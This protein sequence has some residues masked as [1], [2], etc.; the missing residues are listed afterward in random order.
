MQCP[1]ARFLLVGDGP[2][3]KRLQAQHPDCYFV[4]M[5][6]GIALAEHYA[7]SDLFLYPSTSETFGNVILEAMA[8]GLPV[9]SFNYAASREYIH[10]GEN[11][12]AVPLY[13][14]QAFIQASITLAINPTLRENMGKAAYQTALGLGWERVVQRLHTTIQSVLRETSDETVTPA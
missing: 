13:D 12:M 4:G 6:T 3:R 9:V 5:Q 14:E 10:S 8:S 2:E 1:H 11:G 7:C